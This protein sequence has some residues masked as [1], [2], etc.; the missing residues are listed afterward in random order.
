MAVYPTRNGAGIKRRDFT[1]IGA[2]GAGGLTLG[3]YLRLAEAAEVKAA[4]AKSAIFVWL[5]GGPSHLDTFDMKPDAPAEIRG[6]FKTIATNVPGM[7]ICEH[8]PKL[9]ACA[10]KF[11]ILRGITHNI[12]GHEL[13]TVYLNTGNRPVPSLEY[14]GYGAVVSKELPGANDLPHFVAIPST[15]QKAGYLGVR[16]VPLQTNSAPKIG[17]PF[18]VRGIALEDGLTVEQFTGR[19]R[20]LD[21]VD[22]AF[23]ELEGKNALIDGLDRFDQQAYD[24]ISSPTAREAFDTSRESADV[25][26]SFGAHN[27]GQSCLLAMRLVEA[28]VR[29]A[30]VSFSGWDTHSGNFKKSRDDL[31][32][33]LDQGLAALLRTLDVRG[34]LAT[35]TIYVTGEF[36]RTPKINPQAGRDHWPRA[37]ISLLAG[38]GVAGGRV[39]GASDDRGEGP[40]HEQFTPEQVAATFYHT[41][42]ID[43]RKEYHTATGRPVMIVRDGAIIKQ[44]GL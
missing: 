4:K 17:V 8:L 13:G 22:T 9:A 15:P 18:S 36:G 44:L 2:L 37:M 31:L 24:L 41:L 7:N 12:A 42:G 5:G 3:N 43:H 16:S 26:Q 32:P 25:A 21:K 10:D 1:R 19:Q 29:F 14:P 27:F 28:G 35:T 20:L 39:V 38:G 34:L 11:S 30:T 33:Q 23:R 6:E 40:A